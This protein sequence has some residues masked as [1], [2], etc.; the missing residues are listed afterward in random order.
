[1]T[2]SL[3]DELTLMAAKLAAKLHNPAL[4]GLFP[5]SL[6]G[7]PGACKQ[8]ILESVAQ[9]MFEA[10]LYFSDIMQPCIADPEN[11]SPDFMDLQMAYHLAREALSEVYQEPL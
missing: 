1:M 10:L 2:D 7:N 8:R 11:N 9:K 5:D 6:T 4:K 3:D